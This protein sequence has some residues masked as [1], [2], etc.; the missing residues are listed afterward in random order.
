MNMEELPPVQPNHV[1]PDVVINAVEAA[2]RLQRELAGLGIASDVHHGHCLALV[3]VWSGLVVWTDERV[4]RWKSG[5]D[6]LRREARDRLG[7]DAYGPVD[8]PAGTAQRVAA[9]Y[10]E[11]RRMAPPLVTPTGWAPQ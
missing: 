5:R 11:L 9:R 6:A 4:F 8:D 7:W 1:G 3:S 2:E 10:A